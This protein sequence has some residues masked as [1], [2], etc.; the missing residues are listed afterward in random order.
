MTGATLSS[1]VTVT[2]SLPWS[3]SSHRCRSTVIVLLPKLS[4][5]LNCRWR[6][7]GRGCTGVVGGRVVS[8]T[9]ASVV[10]LPL[11]GVVIVISAAL[12]SRRVT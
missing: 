6:G 7:T 9:V 11:A 4:G 5:T 12:L 10:L 1:R 8:V 3:C 2:D